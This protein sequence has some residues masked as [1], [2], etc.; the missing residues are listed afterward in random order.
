MHALHAE[1]HER[2]CRVSTMLEVLSDDQ[3]FF[4]RRVSQLFVVSSFS[5]DAC[6]LSCD[7][8]V[9]TGAIPPL[10]YLIPRNLCMAVK[11]SC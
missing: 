5:I 3:F 4:S 6:V 1:A 2:L 9:V 10:F 11:I 7:E 8:W